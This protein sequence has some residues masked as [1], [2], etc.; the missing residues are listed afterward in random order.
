MSNDD[1][2][3]SH[4]G[5]NENFASNDVLSRVI[6]ANYRDRVRKSSVRRSIEHGRR[7]QYVR[8][9][10]ESFSVNGDDKYRGTNARQTHGRGIA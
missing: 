10:D 4:G 9:A 5:R 8:A 6:T 2:R 7:R 1:D 3:R